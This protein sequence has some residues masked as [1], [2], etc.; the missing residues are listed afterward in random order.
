[1]RISSPAIT[2]SNGSSSGWP[3][4]TKAPRRS[5]SPGLFGLSPCQ[6]VWSHDGRR[7]RRRLGGLQELQVELFFELTPELRAFAPAHFG[8]DRAADGE[9]QGDLR[10]DGH[11]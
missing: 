11:F 5:R 9:I 1:M 3:S 7:V 6:I 2:R 4:S 8:S 10:S